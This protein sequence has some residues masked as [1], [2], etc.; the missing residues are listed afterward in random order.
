MQKNRQTE[1]HTH[2]NRYTQTY[3]D[4]DTSKHR[5]KHIN[6]TYIDTNIYSHMEAQTHRQHTRRYTNIDS[7]TH[8]EIR[9]ES[10]TQRHRNIHSQIHK[11]RY[12]PPET[13]IYAHTQDV[14]SS[15]HLEEGSNK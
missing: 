14:R 12:R 13:H 3:R 7:N 15:N 11:Q 1:T 9:K 5:Q 4:I 2:I 6:I 10:H 8:I